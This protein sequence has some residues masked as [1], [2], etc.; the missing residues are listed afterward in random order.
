MYRHEFD[1]VTEARHFLSKRRVTDV[2]VVAG[3]DSFRFEGDLIRIENVAHP[4]SRGFLQAFCEYMRPRIPVKFATEIPADLFQEVGNRLMRHHDV[5]GKKLVVRIEQWDEQ[6]APWAWASA[7]VTEEYRFIDHERILDAASLAGADKGCVLLTDK[8]LRV[9]SASRPFSV[10]VN[11]HRDE[12]RCGFEIINSESRFYQISVARY[13]LRLVCTNGMVVRLPGEMAFKHRHVIEPTRAL[14]RLSEVLGHGPTW[15]TADVAFQQR[16]ETLATSPADGTW[17]RLRQ[18]EMGSVIGAKT[19]Q[20]AMENLEPSRPGEPPTQF[21]VMN[22]M[23]RVARELKDVDRRRTLEIHA[24][25]LI[26]R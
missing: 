15:A 4:I 14:T 22:V 12:F 23:A 6:G 21:D 17:L 5:K 16:L 10:K 2:P 1:S 3:S 19:A 20:A 13:L 18:A 24:G 26:W 11:G 9:T 8:I 25:N 7:I